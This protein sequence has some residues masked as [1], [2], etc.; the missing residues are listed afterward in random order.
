[1]K[2][3]FKLMGMALIAGSLMFVAC[4]K[5]EEE[6]NNNN[7]NGGNN[8]GTTTTASYKITFGDKTW[9]PGKVIFI[10]N[11]SDDYMGIYAFYNEEEYESFM[12][13]AQQ[14]GAQYAPLFLEKAYVAGTMMS[15]T[16][17]FDYQ[18]SE[19]D[20]MTYRDPSYIYTLTEDL[21][22]NGDTIEAGDYIRYNAISSS[23]VE[24]IT[25]IDLNSRTMT[26]TWSENCFDFEEAYVTN[27]GQS[28]GTLYPINGA[29][30][31][32]KWVW[33]E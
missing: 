6:E 25:A 10:D 17:E 28:Y 9:E 33:Y 18:S 1:M 24:N 29:F 16:G 13:A 11:T 5:D 31:N 23:F 20:K 15:T 8:G 3:I 12:S 14:Y 7:N 27:Q 19:G 4:N 21:V 30:T 26:A 2:N 22:L 32:Y